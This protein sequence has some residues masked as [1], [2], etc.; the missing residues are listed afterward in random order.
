MLLA[1]W[2]HAGACA[3]ALDT[4]TGTPVAIKKLTKPF[5]CAESA[6]RTLRE[7][8]ILRS[9]RGCRRNRVLR[10]LDAFTPT[11]TAALPG[12]A[13]PVYLVTE[14]APTTLA[15]IIDSN[16]LEETHVLFLMYQVLPCCGVC[17]PTVTAPGPS[18]AGPALLRCIIRRP[19][20]WRRSVRATAP[21]RSPPPPP[22]CHR[23]Q[24]APALRALP[25]P[26]T[27]KHTPPA[28]PPR[29]IYRSLSA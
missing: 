28:A 19:V 11:D 5:E 15:G 1:D 2:P 6:K 14:L 8:H 26:S 13:Y 20:G 25:A 29:F 9:I 3:Q 18:T 21:R 17:S 24:G 4:Q 27:H 12:V 7:T 16:T 22:P 23:H 10:L